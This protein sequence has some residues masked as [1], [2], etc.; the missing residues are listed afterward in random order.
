MFIKDI[1]SATGT[2][3]V[4]LMFLNGFIY[5]RLIHNQFNRRQIVLR[6]FMIMHVLMYLSGQF[7]P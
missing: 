4:N 5:T 1:M 3:K 7:W 2:T 6:V